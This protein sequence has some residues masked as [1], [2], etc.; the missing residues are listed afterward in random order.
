ML[1]HRMFRL[2]MAIM[3]VSATTVTPAL[4]QVPDPSDTEAWLAMLNEIA[5]LEDVVPGTDEETQPSYLFGQSNDAW[6]EDSVL[7]A[8][9]LGAT[10]LR[11]SWGKI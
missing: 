2:T 6:T 9:R 10:T 7:M 3:V 4:G 5:A 11:L 1:I 8:E